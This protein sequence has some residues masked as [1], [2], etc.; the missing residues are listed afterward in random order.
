MKKLSLTWQIMIALVM[1]VLAGY[2]LQSDT[3]FAET[4]IKPVGTIFL[5]LL[6][7]IVV[8]MVLLSIISG[9]LSMKDLSKVG[10]LGLNTILY[11]AATTVIA[12]VLGLGVSTLFK[13]WFSGIHLD[14]TNGELPEVPEIS[15]IDQFVDFFPRNFIEP[16][17]MTNL[18]QVIVIAV[19]FGVAIV[20]IGKKGEAV[21][22]FI[23]GFNEVVTQVLSYI[24][25]ISPLGVFCMLTPV[26][27]VNGPSVLSSYA[28]LIGLTYFCFLL[29]AMA[30]YAPA[31]RFMG[32]CGSR[33][34]FKTMAPAMLF[35]F[36]S[37]SSVATLPYSMEC[38]QKLGV[39]KD[40]GSFILSLGATINMNGVSIYLSVVSVF[41]ATCCGIELS[42]SQYMAIALSSTVASIGTPGIP[43]G[44]LALM[45]MVFS[46]AG[47]PVECVAIAAGIDRVIDMGRTVMSITG[48]ASCA[49][50]MEHIEKKKEK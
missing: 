13:K 43:G 10:R 41:M 42:I 2:F 7:F 22:E 35:A 44:A 15:M 6:K 5:N 17:Y 34:F 24:M 1:A 9:I 47:I 30:V 31:V 11:F 40:R 20:Q 27:A 8:P 50:V 45:A 46:S 14:I 23:L 3:G 26:V 12:V 16:F 28:I 19:I 37:D 18:M 32:G 48:D 36:S 39:R 4:Y 25:A 49:V 33:K 21:R 38:T 29:H